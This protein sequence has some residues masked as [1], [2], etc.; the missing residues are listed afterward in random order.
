MAVCAP[1]TERDMFAEKKKTFEALLQATKATAKANAKVKAKAK[2][3]K[4]TAGVV[5]TEDL[6]GRRRGLR[7]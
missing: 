7:Q 5:L 3:T 2:A 6:F 1:L 4:V